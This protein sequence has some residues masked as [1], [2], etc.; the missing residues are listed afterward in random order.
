MRNPWIQFQERLELV[1]DLLSSFIIMIEDMYVY[2]L[3]D[4]IKKR[5]NNFSDYF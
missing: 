4:E 1:D 3:K 2:D 5:F